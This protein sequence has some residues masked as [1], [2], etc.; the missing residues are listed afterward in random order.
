MNLSVVLFGL[1]FLG[2]SL[3][4]I[5]SLLTIKDDLFVITNRHKVKQK[6]REE[7]KLVGGTNIVIRP[8]YG[9][10]YYVTFT[11][12]YGLLESID[13]SFTPNYAARDFVLRWHNSTASPNPSNRPNFKPVTNSSS[14]EQ[15]IDDMASEIEELKQKLQGWEKGSVKKS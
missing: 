5:G 1:I 3:F 7:L 8:A 12:E 9:W 6:I 15:I 13:V 11:N 2:I 4:V 10:H 14:K